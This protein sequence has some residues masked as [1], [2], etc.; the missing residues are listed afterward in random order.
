MQTA[1][2][3]IPELVL[4]V[5]GTYAAREKDEGENWWQ[6]GSLSYEGMRRRLPPH[7][8]L[9]GPTEVFH[10]SGENSERARIKA[11]FELL[12]RLKQY[13]KER[14]PY[15]LIG[16]SHGGSVIWHTLRMA[17]LNR[18]ELPHLRSWATVGTPYLRHT[19]QRSS[20]LTNML[21]L[22]IGIALAKPAYTTAVRFFDLL[23]RPQQSAWLGQDDK[24]PASFTLYDTPVLRLLELMRVPITRTASGMKIGSY[25]PDSGASH[26]QFLFTTPVGWLII[27]LAVIV[28][29]IYLNLAAYFLRPLIESWQVW[30]ETHLERHAKT[31]FAS[32]WLAIWSPQ[33]E[34]INGLRATLDL[35]VEFVARM[36]PRD[37][38]LFS[39][40]ATIAMQPYYWVMTPVFNKLLRP[41][42]DRMVRSFVVKSAQGNNRPGTEVVEV[43]VAP[44]HVDAS[45]QPQPLPAWFN[46]QLVHEANESAKEVVPKL[47][48]LL[49]APSF[50]TGLKSF[51]Q[52]SKGG[53]LVHTS[54]FDHEEVLD[55]LAMHI[56]GASEVA[57]WHEHGLSSQSHDLAK[58]LSEAKLRVGNQWFAWQLEKATH[59]STPQSAI[60]TGQRPRRRSGLSR[61]A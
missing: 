33:D 45:T 56:A 9:T 15:H 57:G 10:W 14:R 19:L 53:E 29:T 42:L 1:N 59:V 47:R 55:L 24:L 4:Q 49:A 28:I 40:Y 54:Y 37:R 41:F 38:V 6:I 51:S 21:R 25:D 22:V 36:V 18:L 58:W 61:A 20:L 44:W 26:L 60:R 2:P 50:T 43:S 3:P 11:A 32:R 13:E 5:H 52:S 7:T 30:A 12:T 16:H 31:Q 35:S 8:E 34:A 17:T 46:E 39:D 23:F 48:N 27:A